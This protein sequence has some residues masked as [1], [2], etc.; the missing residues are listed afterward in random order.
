MF[1][2]NDTDFF[3]PTEQ[4]EV[5]H[6]FCWAAL[7]DQIDGTTYTDLTG[8]FPTMSMENNQ[9][10]FVAYDYTTNAILVRAI[11]NREATTIAK[12]F[13]DV[14]SYLE[15][16]GFKPK[17]NVLD[18]EASSA[19]TNFL[20]SQD[21]KYQFVP[22][23]EHRV[24][25]A[26]RAIQTFKNHFISGLCTT[27]RDFP[28]QLW[29]KLLPQ[30]QD[31]LNMLRT[32]RI[33]P[34]KSAYEVLEGQHDFN[35]HPWAPPGCRAV[36]HEH[37]ENRTSWGPRGTDAWYIGSAPEHYRSYEFYVPDTRAYR[38][39]NSAQFFPS[40]ANIPQETDIEAATR[41]AA[42]L[43]IELRR[44]ANPKD[45]TKLSR[46]QQA[47][48][49]I[50]DIFHRIKQQPPRVEDPNHP[51][52]RVEATLSSNPTA[53]KVVKS[54]PRRHNRLTRNNTPGLAEQPQPTPTRRSPRLNP[55]PTPAT[56]QQEVPSAP[57]VAEEPVGPSFDGDDD[58]VIVPITSIP[59][60]IINVRVPHLIPQ[61][62][63]NAF[64]T[65][66]LHQCS[67]AFIPHKFAPTSAPDL[68]HFANPV[69]HPITG[70]T[71]D[72][73]EK[74]ANDPIMRDVWT[75]A[76][77]KELG[78]LAQGDNKTG[79]AGTDTVFFMNH[80]EIKNIPKDRTV[81]YARVVVD[82]RPQKQDP[83]RVRITVGGN[84]IDY[85]GELTTRTADLVTSKILWNSIVST[86]DAR[87]VT[88]DL[89]LFYLTAPMD[90]YEYMRMPLRIIPEQL[91]EQYDLR[92]KAKNG[93]V[94]MEIRRAMYG[95]PQAGILANK[96][97]K[98][99]LA[100]HGYYEVTHTPGL[101]KHISRPVQFTLVVDDFGIKYVGKEHADHLLNAL[102]E[103]YTL[104][105][106]WNGELYCGISLK[107]DYKN[108]H[109]DISI[110]M[111]GYIKKLLQR[112]QHECKKPQHSPHFSPHKN[113]AKTLKNHSLPT[114]HPNW[115]R[116]VSQEFNKS[117]E[118]FYIMLDASTSPFS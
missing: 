30:A 9:Y 91:I 71:I 109:V 67:N 66:S 31:S 15:T 108:R 21:I 39:S 115:I 105:I 1:V 69:V 48:K 16:K 112:F 62:A 113:T 14:F 92:S 64:A 25:A 10:V 93:F 80:D 37:A 96:L 55:L 24:N 41:T 49:V 85:P 94:Y 35:R 58:S 50:N 65:S 78:S 87:Y 12:A 90:R 40:F 53:P 2:N 11:P 22:P 57:T 81:T 32:S 18:N 33:D 46:H 29:D 111:P 17:F 99:R 95:L 84:L 117:L 114:L 45:P 118:L 116:P 70:E 75:T 97:L 6:V 79:A 38:I 107:W 63:L 51:T 88:A 13:Q 89:K 101:W 56:T 72:K 34:T 42:E 77:G 26:E 103:H 36:I 68:E 4:N 82:Y 86:P 100:K 43:I 60:E 104:D 47:I 7:A 61:D 27:D 54:K 102:Q 5:N 74:L 3:P 110:S 98:E 83:N 28:F 52:P 8:R 106:D 73:Y 44:S 20:R 76:F 59:K 19:I 23:N